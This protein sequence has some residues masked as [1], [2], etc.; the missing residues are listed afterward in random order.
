MKNNVF[1]KIIIII[2]SKETNVEI[3]EIK[4]GI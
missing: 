3:I 1:M 2:N 4:N